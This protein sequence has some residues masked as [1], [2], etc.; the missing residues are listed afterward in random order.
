MKNEYTVTKRLIRSWENGWWFNSAANT[1]LLIF[2]CISAILF[3]IFPQIFSYYFGYYA[4]SN[5]TLKSLYTA[6]W[7]ICHVG[8]LFLLLYTP[9]ASRI[10]YSNPYSPNHQ[11][12]YYKTCSKNYCVKKWQRA[13]ELTED[14]I[15]VTDHNSV[16]RFEYST[17]KR[18]KERRKSVIIFLKS[19][20]EIRMY[21]NAFVEGSWEECKKL[22]SRKSL[23][24]V[25]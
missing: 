1:A 10:M 24:N 7:Y 17:I 13:I 15:I 2:T 12:N 14:E 9:S 11:Y 18:V 21:K 4:T 16:L 3:F 20:F 19:G 6:L 5:A 25:K 8:T 23:V 22:I